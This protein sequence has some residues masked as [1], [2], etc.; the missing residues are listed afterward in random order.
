MYGG[1]T[2]NANATLDEMWV[3]HMDAVA[4]GSKTL[5]LP[6][7]V[8]EKQPNKEGGPGGLRGH[9]A[10]GFQQYLIIFGGVNADQECTNTIHLYDT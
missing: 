1:H 10:V 7:I 6:G 2:T 4:W 8:W 3:L 5:E 9:A